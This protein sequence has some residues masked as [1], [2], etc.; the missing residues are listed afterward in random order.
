[1]YRVDESLMCLLYVVVSLQE[2][3]FLLLLLLSLFPDLVVGAFESKVAI[4][5]RYILPDV[6]GQHVFVLSCKFLTCKHKNMHVSM[7]FPY[8]HMYSGTSIR[9]RSLVQ[10]QASSLVRSWLVT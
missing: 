4:V 1:M 9:V 3:S 5:I 10:N 6:L 8:M 7:S 2:I